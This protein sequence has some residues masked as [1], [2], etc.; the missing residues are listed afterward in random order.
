[1]FEILHQAEVMATSLADQRRLILVTAGQSE[2]EQHAGSSDRALAAA[3]RAAAMADALGDAEVQIVAHHRLGL[4]RSLHGH[5]RLTVASLRRCLDLLDEQARVEPSSRLEGLT[6]SVRGFQALTMSELGD[7]TEAMAVGA[8]GLRIAEEVGHPLSLAAVLALCGIAHVRR[9]KLQDAIP[10]LERG[11]QITERAEL[12]HWQAR[13]AA[14]LSLAYARVGRLEEGSTAAETAVR[15]AQSGQFLS[16]FQALLLEAQ[17]A[18]GDL[19][20]AAG[21]A[22]DLLADARSRD[23]CAQAWMLRLLGEI[24]TCRNPPAQEVAER[25]YRASLALAT[26]LDMRP[27]QARCHLGLGTLYR[28]IGRRD[29]AGTELSTALA[30]LRAMEMMFWLPE[31]EAGLAQAEAPAEH[32][33]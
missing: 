18:L 26:E 12:Q 14:T 24:A 2:V 25:Q 21:Q 6:V 10:L 13:I 16:T 9:G 28:Q 4:T 15:M 5:L 19:D 23:R 33:G 11:L 31:A 30:M 22:E 27:L 1:M 29:A 7:F 17:A 3:E 20:R 8:L 32:I